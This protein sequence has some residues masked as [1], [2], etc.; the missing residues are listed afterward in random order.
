MATA[1]CWTLCWPLDLKNK[2]WTQLSFIF[3]S[4]H[5][6]LISFSSN[7][8]QHLFLITFCYLMSNLTCLELK[9]VYS[10]KRALFVCSKAKINHHS[11][12]TTH[13][14]YAL[15]AEATASGCYCNLSDGHEAA[16]VAIKQTASIKLVAN[17][18]PKVYTLVL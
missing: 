2:M 6:L 13:W 14:T 4:S 18:W 15:K 16:K 3:N 7:S 8:I 10:S 12:L 5:L 17:P 1:K 9:H 11:Y